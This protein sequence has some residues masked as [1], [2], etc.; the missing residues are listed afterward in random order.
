MPRTLAVVAEQLEWH[1]A[2]DKE[3]GLA[4]TAPPSAPTHPQPSSLFPA[5]TLYDTALDAFYLKIKGDRAVSGQVPLA[6]NVVTV[7]RYSTP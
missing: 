1:P 3:G 6:V 2:T 4:P 5:H 7:V